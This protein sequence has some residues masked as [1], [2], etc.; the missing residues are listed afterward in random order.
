M[1]NINAFIDGQ[2]FR[3]VLNYE[4]NNLECAVIIRKLTITKAENIKYI[5]LETAPEKY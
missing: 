3:V 1:I 4:K 5:L 2:P